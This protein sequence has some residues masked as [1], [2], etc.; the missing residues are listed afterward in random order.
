MG[1]LGFGMRK[2]VY[3]RKPKEAFKTLKKFYG[4]DTPKIKHNPDAPKLTSE[5]ILNRPRFK[6]FYDTQAYKFLKIAIFLLALGA[7]LNYSFVQP[8][9]FDR[10]V[11]AYKDS[12]ITTYSSDYDFLLNTG[13]ELKDLSS[14]SIDSTYSVFM[15]LIKNMEYQESYSDDSQEVAK[16]GVW[17]MNA[18]AIRF[19]G[20]AILI[21]R[22]DSTQVLQHKWMVIYKGDTSQSSYHELLK[23]L[24][25]ERSYIAKLGSK[26]KLTKTKEV[27]YENEI[28]TLKIDETW[29]FGR[30]YFKR[31]KKK[32]KE[33]ENIIKIDTMTYLKSR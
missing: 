19:N 28:T 18:S 22:P 23:H 5:E 31:T 4:N 14:F 33:S 8:W 17:G 13:N 10:E 2:E 11:E 30:H 1:F 16:I 3:K 29:E 25:V 21:D 6:S 24:G 27:E 20:D 7:F 12:L 15:V 9:L 26:L 32:F